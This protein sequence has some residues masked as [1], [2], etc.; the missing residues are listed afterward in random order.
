MQLRPVLLYTYGMYCPQCGVEYREGYSS[1]SDCH[2]LLVRERPQTGDATTVAPGDPNRDPFCAFWQGTDARVLAELGTVLDEAGI[3]Y[4][5]VRREDHLFNRMDQPLLRLGV[6]ASLYEKAEQVVGDAFS[7][8]PLL[9]DTSGFIPERLEKRLDFDENEPAMELED[10]PITEDA[11]SSQSSALLEQWF[12]EDANVEVWRGDLSDAWML[13]MSLKENEIR[14]RSETENEKKQ[15]F[16]VPEE[17]TRAR[18]II[19][20]IL[21]ASPPE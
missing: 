14:F 9:R 10:S 18:E 16:V 12:P 13:E 20:E 2:V 5:T 1:C 4:K 17:E 19:R 3:P 21:E 6:P 7:A 8:Q 15:L 11:G